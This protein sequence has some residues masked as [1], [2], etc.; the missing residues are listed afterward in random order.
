MKTTNLQ[1]KGDKP[2]DIRTEPQDVAVG[3][4]ALITFMGQQV[5]V[6]L[7]DSSTDVEVIACPRLYDL[8]YY[9]VENKMFP[10]TVD[11]E[12]LMILS[13]AVL[14]PEN[15]PYEINSDEEVFVIYDEW[16]FNRYDS[17]VAVT[18]NIENIIKTY[19]NASIEDFIIMIG[20]E[21]MVHSKRA[22]ISRID[23]WRAMSWA[24]D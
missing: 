22:F 21:L 10:K 18:K 20:R 13:V 4:D 5:G 2:E 3:I 15:L 16:D 19:P 23:Y 12:S 11:E 6:L 14:D 17:V 8:P 9:A 24:E 7:Y 1:K